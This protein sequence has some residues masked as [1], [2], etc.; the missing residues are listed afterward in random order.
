MNSPDEPALEDQG[1]RGSLRNK[2][3]SRK[4]LRVATAA[5]IALG[6]T[7]VGAGAAGAATNGTGSPHA[8]HTGMPGSNGSNGRGRPA[9][10]G[11]VATVGTNSFTVTTRSGS[12]LTVDITDATTY[13][14]HGV[15]SPSFA[16]VKVGETVVVFGTETSGTVAATSVG[17]GT[18]AGPGGSFSGRPASRPGGR[19]GG[20]G[21]RAGARPTRPPTGTAA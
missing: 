2:G 16:N 11:T 9:V 4:G 15:T 8:H 13:R 6:L 20:S 7:V 3:R 18:S 14:D 12:T 5:G 17:I 21:G 10:T 1:G 19:P